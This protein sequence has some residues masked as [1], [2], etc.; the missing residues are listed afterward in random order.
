MSVRF[1]Y[2]VRHG[3]E[4]HAEK[5][6]ELGGPLTE[7]GM[8]Q[9]TATAEFLR[10]VP[11]TAVYTSTLRRAAQ[12]ASLL[13]AHHSHL[14]A[15]ATTLLWECVPSIPL[16]LRESMSYLRPEQLAAEQARITQAFNTYLALPEPGQVHHDLVVCHGN[17]IRYFVC[18][19]LETPPDLWLNLEIAN[20]GI[21][22][23]EIRP[24]G[25]MVLVAHNLYN[26]LPHS[27][28]TYI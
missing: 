22:Q 25:R 7:T 1:V 20:C 2:L 27:L 4:N 3:Q 10:Y 17:L 9:A 23:M 19:V 11:L 16:I 26:H 12:T 28:R 24:N 8:A 18:R 15:Q 13:L 21:T 14:T 5:H 6:D